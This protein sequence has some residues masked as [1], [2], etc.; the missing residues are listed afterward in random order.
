M[1]Y[2]RFEELEIWQLARTLVSD[3]YKMTLSGK[4]LKDFALRDQMRRC[5]VSVMSNIAEGFE[6]HTNK[7]FINFLFIAKGSCGEFRS[8]LYV[9]LDCGYITDEDFEKYS[10]S[11][12]TIS[13]SISGFIK[14]LT[15]N[16]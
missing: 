16:S 10:Q 8:Q 11:C 15:N 12:Q 1:N 3:T 7:E 4:F 2:K 13:K 14:Y 6:R 9:A 5:A